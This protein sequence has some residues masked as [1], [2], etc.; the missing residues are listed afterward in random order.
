MMMRTS[1]T[2]LLSIAACVWAIILP[3]TAFVTHPHTTDIPLLGRKLR[4]CQ[5]PYPSNLQRRYLTSLQS[6]KNKNNKEDEPPKN[7]TIFITKDGLQLSENSSSSNKD[8]DD[9]AP[10][11]LS[12]SPPDDPPA[13]QF[14]SLFANAK[15]LTPIRA[16]TSDQA[17][18]HALMTN[19]TAAFQKETLTPL[20]LFQR[21]LQLTHEYLDWATQYPPVPGSLG[22]VGGS[23]NVV[24]SHVFK[25]LYRYFEEQPD[26]RTQLAHST[27][28]TSIPVVRTILQELQSRYDERADWEAR[29]SSHTGS[30]W[31]RRHREAA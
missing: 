29:P 8:D 2:T 5:R 13:S 15:S 25:L 24:R 6:D 21:Q 10:T 3:T 18:V 31:Y 1:F 27:T 12:S 19:A 20:Q 11:T 28:T 22:K 23:F 9:T 7:P 4:I 30:S 14:E 17:A 16:M 26:L